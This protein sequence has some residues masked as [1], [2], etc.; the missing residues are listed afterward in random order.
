[1]NFQ[2][3]GEP[4]GASHY[5]QI[6]EIVKQLRGEAEARQLDKARVGLAQVFGAW[7]HCGV[8]ILKQGW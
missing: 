4:L 7:G 8:S 1:M 6:Y 3:K 5:G 2:S